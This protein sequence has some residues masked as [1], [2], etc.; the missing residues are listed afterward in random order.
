MASTEPLNSLKRSDSSFT[1]EEIP[2]DVKWDV[3]EDEVVHS[4]HLINLCYM[5]VKQKTSSVWMKLQ[6]IQES[7]SS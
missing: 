4:P 1:S 6:A 7:L 5:Y 3:D 2:L